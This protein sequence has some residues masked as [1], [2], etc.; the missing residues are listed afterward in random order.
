MGA[1]N[2]VG[3]AAMLGYVRSSWSLL[4]LYGSQGVN[5]LAGFAYG[6]L[7][8]VYIQPAQLGAYNVQLAGLLLLNACFIA[9]L[10][11][12]FKFALQR[13]PLQTVVQFHTGLLWRIC[14][15]VA[16]SLAVSVY[17]TTLPRHLGFL[18]VTLLLQSVFT[19][20]S[21][22]LNTTFQYRSIALLQVL[23]PVLNLLLLI[24]AL[25]IWPGSQTVGL[26]LN[27]GTLYLLLLGIAWLLAHRAQLTN[28]IAIT[29]SLPPHWRAEW[30]A[31]RAYTAPLAVYGIFGWAT[32]Y[33]D[34]YLINHFLT[35]QDVGYYTIGYSLGA[36]IAIL[37]SPL[38]AHLTPIVLKAYQQSAPGRAAQ[39]DIRKHLLLFWGLSLPACLFLFLLNDEIGK[40]FMSSTYKPAFLIAPLIALAYV[41]LL[42]NQFLETKFYATGHT[43]YVLWHSIAGAS[44]NVCFNIWLIPV[45]GIRGAAIAMIISSCCQFIFVCYLFSKGNG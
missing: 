31:F 16:V 34:R 8:A 21:D 32:A 35:T 1:T 29:W 43:K 9:P 20:I 3:R 7:T 4:L 2:T 17:T 37:S 30:P 26:W 28:G 22:Y 18:W 10:I 13:Q 5:A 14:L 45:M 15:A 12:S 27:Y 33:I 6:K 39:K 40:L 41:F 38:L 36:R 25:T 23:N 44:L 42:S 19:F 24:A 11:Q